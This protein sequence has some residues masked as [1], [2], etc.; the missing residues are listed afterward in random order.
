[1]DIPPQ[2]ADDLT[3]L[4]GNLLP[5]HRADRTDVTA[6]AALLPGP[7]DSYLATTATNANDLAILA[8]RL[9]SAVADRLE[10]RDPTLDDDV[11][12]W[13]SEKC[14]YPRLSLLGPVKARCYGRP[15]AKQKAYY[16]EALAYL[17]LHR[18][19]VTGDQIA[20]A[21]GLSVP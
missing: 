19:G 8:P 3:D 14:P 12:A 13:F 11:R 21:F 9:E 15:M 16:T 4:T 1:D 7:D 5:E 10:S 6:M 20:D 18:D 17:A 2:A